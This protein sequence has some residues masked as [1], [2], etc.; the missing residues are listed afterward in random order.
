VG[1]LAAVE[2]LICENRQRSGIDIMFKHNLRAIQLAPPLECAVF[3]IVQESL[4][5]ACRHSGGDFIRVELQESD[6]RL[7]IVVFD[8]GVG[9]DPAAV[10]EDR[11]GLRSIRERARLLGGKAEF[12]S[13]PGEGCRIIIELPL[14]PAAGE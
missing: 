12:Q 7:Q 6:D 4:I 2:Y 8:E 13:A 1:I 5:N 14:V 11:F 9:F 10:P 3:R